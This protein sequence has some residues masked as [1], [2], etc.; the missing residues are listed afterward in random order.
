MLDDMEALDDRYA[1][2]EPLPEQVVAEVR[3]RQ[4]APLDMSLTVDAL[5]D[6][7]C[8]KYGWDRQDFERLRRAES[9]R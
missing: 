4:D 2:A 8:V 3:R 1:I 9:G 6:D 7:L 5:A